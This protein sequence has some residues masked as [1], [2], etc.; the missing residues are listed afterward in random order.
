[1]KKNDEVI[2]RILPVAI[3]VAVV[4]ILVMMTLG[5]ARADVPGKKTPAGTSVPN[6]GT[7]EQELANITF[8]AP[9]NVFE[10]TVTCAACHGGTIDHQASHFGNWAGTAMANS[11][12]DPVFRANQQIVNS[13]IRSL[14]GTDG[15]G[16][17]CFRCHTQ[18]GWYSGRTDPLLNG[19][20]DGSTLEH[21]IIL[22]T[23]DEGVNCEACHRAIGAV[24][25][26]RPDLDSFDLVWNMLAGVNDWPHLGSAYPQG[27]KAGD[28]FGGASLQYD[29]GMTYG[30]KY[31]GSVLLSFSDN[32]NFDLLTPYTGQTYGVYPIWWS[33]PRQ[34]PPAGMP[35]TNAAGQEIVY[36]PDGSTSTVFEAPIGPPADANGNPDYQ[37]QA[38]SLEHPTFKGDFITS[39][40]LCAACHELTVN[41]LNHGMPE[42]RTYTEWK[43]S[44]F[45]RDYFQNGAKTRCQDCHMPTLR[46]EY[47]D[48]APVSINADPLVSGWFPYAKDRNPNGGTSFHKFGGANRDLPEM[49]KILYPEVDME[50]LG[51]PTANDVRI[52]P[53]MLSTRNTMWERAR[54]NNEISL[55]DAVSAQISSGPTYNTTTGKWEVKVKVLNNSGHRIPSGYPDGRRFWISLRVKDALGGTVYESGAYDEASA[56]LFTD[57]TKSGLNRALS[58]QIDSANNT[59]MIYEKVTGTCT[60]ASCTSSPSLLNKTILFDNRIPPAGYSLADYQAAGTTFWNYDAATMVPHEDP[61]RYPDG[62]NW[63]EVTYSFNAPSDAVLTAR[64]ELYWQTHTREFM[65]YLK[66]NDTSTYRPVGPPNIMD[67]NYPLTPN[68]LSENILTTTGVDFL[69][70]TDLAGSPLRDN[71]G[72]VAYAAWLLTGKGAPYLVAA[73]D[74][75]VTTTPD[76]PS[77]VSANTIPGDP[78]KLD[79]SW[80]PVANADG[81]NVWIRY[82]LSDATA[83][84]DRLAVVYGGN[85]IVNDAMNVAK[86]YGF[87]VQAFNGKGLSADSMVITAQ[88][89]MDLPLPPENLKVLGV[90]DTTVSLSWYDAADNEAGFIIE[91]QDVPL[92]ASQ[93]MPP[94]VE[95]ARVPTQTPGATGFGGNTFTDTGLSSGRTYNY[96]VAAY[97]VSGPSTYN[98]NGPVAATTTATPPPAPSNLTATTVLANNVPTV[99]LNWTD[100]AFN[101]LGF[102]LQRSTDSL[103][104]RNLTTVSL[105]ANSTT[106]SDTSVMPN[107]T[108]YYRVVAYNNLGSSAASNTASVLTVSSI[109]TAPSNL[110]VSRVRT[111]AISLS[112]RD[113]SNNEDG[114]VVERATN[115]N[116]PWG[117]L[118]QTGT[119]STSNRHFGNRTICISDRHMCNN[120]FRKNAWI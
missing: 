72:G 81:Y 12:R 4:M 108:Y 104:R 31:S 47:S 109:P 11:V 78:F 41:E 79:I 75:S 94:F 15:G 21:S 106:Y 33:G 22:S 50:V 13:A 98:I 114:F 60:P 42:Q 117:F 66:D 7:Q 70:M 2:Y 73:D 87:K 32:P 110:Q 54:R 53:G 1:M 107:T 61:G 23:D 48:T 43:Y 63:D 93:P 91:R 113:R 40:E 97:N 120:L 30:G 59:V 36:G 64:A 28:P 16:N 100:T 67:P 51:G 45:G 34:T 76:A 44:N 10:F 80:S 18:N 96:R 58:P 118:A 35:R 9:Y 24:T 49:M 29:E 101:E 52:F 99:T 8:P 84:W 88:T 39:P 46:H 85:R 82:G 65:E 17:L 111:G 83:S 27:P 3:F 55:R 57:S 115:T 74:T 5:I 77:T 56:T 102:R 19:A 68:Y 25:M 26:K 103:F 62:Q 105:P 119:N 112:W 14:T 86:S 37:S 71:W 95:I 90:T 69:S 38:I 116:G 20:S 6:P 89:A 92:L